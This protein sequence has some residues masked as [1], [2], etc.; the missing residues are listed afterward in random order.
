MHHQRLTDHHN[1]MMWETIPDH[2]DT[3]Q[4]FQT[5]RHPIQSHDVTSGR[6]EAVQIFP[7]SSGLIQHGYDSMANLKTADIFGNVAEVESHDRKWSQNA[8]HQPPTKPFLSVPTDTPTSDGDRLA[9]IENKTVTESEIRLQEYNTVQTLNEVSRYEVGNSFR[10]ARTLFI[11]TMY[12]FNERVNR[13]LVEW[14][15]RMLLTR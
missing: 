3:D 8:S 11:Y 12:V 13:L 7:P 10:S 4:S 2:S 14:V 5:D 1:R 9:L 15:E 6:E